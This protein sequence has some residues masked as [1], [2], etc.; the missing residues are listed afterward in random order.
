MCTAI[1]ESLP[2]VYFSLHEHQ[3]TDELC[4]DIRQKIT[5]GS[6]G[7]EQFQIRKDL[8]CY[9][10]RATKRS[11]WVIPRILRTMVLKYFHDSVFAGHLGAFKTFHK[12]TANFWWPKIRT[13]VFGYVRKCDLCQRAKPA[14][15]TN[16]G[17]HAAQP[18]SLPMEKVFVDFVGPLTRTR[19]GHSAIL[20]VLDGFS[21]FVT[22]YPVRKISSQV[23][24][25]TLERNY[26]PMYGTPRAIVTDN[27]SVF[28]CKQIKQ[29]CFKWASAHITTTPY[30][31]QGSLVERANRNLKSALK[32]FIISPKI[33]G[34]KIFLGLVQRLIP[35]CMR[36]QNS[37][38]MYCFWAEK[39]R[40]PLVPGGI[41]SHDKA[42]KGMTSQTFWTQAYSNLK[43]A[44]DRVAHRYNENRKPHQYK[45]GDLVMFKRNL[46]SS[47]A[48]KVTG[49]L[50]MRWSQ[51]VVIAKF[52]G[53]NNVLLANPDTGVIIRRAHVSQLKP[54]VN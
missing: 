34:M 53:V 28:R 52:S 30:Y 33:G 50:S 10:P 14:Q 49:K 27:V 32:V 2:L 4:V 17:L 25:D 20:A 16:V 24:V 35:R 54:Y 19:R 40:A 29:M 42:T 38:P 37:R 21:K 15:D 45:V 46:V 11:K 48:Q 6:P 44:R 22:F 12:I 31:P 26:F 23:V 3:L 51:P 18:P 39:L 36:V 5:S 47:K 8:V 1:L 9:V 7:A 43:A 41:C 13:D